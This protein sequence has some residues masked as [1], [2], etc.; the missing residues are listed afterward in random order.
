MTFLVT[1]RGAPFSAAGFGNWFRERCDEAGL[2]QCSAHGLRHASA[3]R[4]ANIGCTDEEI[5]A[6]T[7][8]RSRAS[9]AVYTRGADQV[10]LARRALAKLTNSE[11]TL[12]QHPN[13]LDQ[14]RRK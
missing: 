13:P 10:R 12:V 14:D 7:G 2:P 8:H 3:T 6:F 11:R 1:E 4:F 5:M 9:L